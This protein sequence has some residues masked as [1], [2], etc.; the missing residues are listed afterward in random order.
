MTF[1]QT[2]QVE[3]WDA[4]YNL[5]A[6][7]KVAFI[8]GLIVPAVVAAILGYF[9]FS[10][11]VKG[12]FFSLITL[13]IANVFELLISNQQRYT[14]GAN[15][16]TRVPRKLFFDKLFPMKEYYFVML[17]LLVVIYIACRLLTKSKFGIILVAIRENEQRMSFFGYNPANFKIAI[18]AISGAIAGLAGMMFA[19][20]SSFIT[21]SNIGISFSTTI[22]VWLALGGRGNLTG[23]S[24]GTLIICWA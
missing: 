3:R 18:F 22:I 10:Q 7:T 4:F 23:A 1:R 13:A 19:T 5:I 17:A 9:L 11:K 21:P 12:V 14:G 20:T 8:L 6:N 16:I 24:I 2:A 15:G